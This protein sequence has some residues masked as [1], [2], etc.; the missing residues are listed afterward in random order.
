MPVMPCSK[1]FNDSRFLVS[2][3][4]SNPGDLAAAVIAGMATLAREADAIGPRM[5]TVAVHARWTGQPNRA[6]GLRRILEHGLAVPG[7]AF[8]RRDDMAR[9]VLAHHG[10]LPTLPP[11]LVQGGAAPRRPCRPPSPGV[12]GEQ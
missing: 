2:P 11:M 12:F 6:S 10:H 5:M 1:T 4:Y 7:V 3:G 9:H 8:L